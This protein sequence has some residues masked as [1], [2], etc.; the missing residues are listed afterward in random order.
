MQITGIRTRRCGDALLVAVDTSDGR[1]GVG[2]S[3][4]WA[5]PASVEAVIGRFGEYLVG[6]DPS[7]IERHWHMM[8]RMAP[9]R[10]AIVASAVS[11]VDVALW[12]LAGQRLGVPVYELLGG[13]FRDRIRL[14]RMIEAADSDSLARMARAGVQ[15]DF[16]RLPESVPF[17][18]AALHD[19]VPRRV[20]G[21]VATAR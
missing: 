18:A 15:S 20:D 16:D 19:E 2:E 3:V 13:R 8:W 6:R 4:C 21:S 9:F 11:A 17:I 5:Y 12:D 10:G 14:H 1:T 7:T